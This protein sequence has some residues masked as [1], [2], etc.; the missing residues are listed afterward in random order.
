MDCSSSRC[1]TPRRHSPEKV[2]LHPHRH[3]HLLFVYMYDDEVLELRHAGPI[4]LLSS[5][6]LFFANV[7]CPDISKLEHA[8]RERLLCHAPAPVRR[9]SHPV[10]L[11]RTSSLL[12][13]SVGDLCFTCDV[14]EM[15]ASVQVA[16]PSKAHVL[17]T[18]AASWDNLRYEFR[19]VGVGSRSQCVQHE[20]DAVV[21]CM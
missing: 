15:H 20:P 18:D 8:G 9:V 4:R 21:V 1:V 17:R 10:Y 19:Y 13:R 12:V 6:H 2:P 14:L 5:F 7:L 16:P 3:I 11:C